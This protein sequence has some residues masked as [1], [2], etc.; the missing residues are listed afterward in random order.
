M[1]IL[2]EC[3][4][5]RHR[6]YDDTLPCKKCGTRLAKFSGKTYW[7]EFY[8]K[9]GR[10]KRERIG[11]NKALAETVHRKRLVERAEGKLLDKKKGDKIRFDQLAK[12]YLSLAEVKTKKSFIRDERSIKKLEYFFKTKLITSISPS[13]I[14]NYQSQRLAEKSYRGGETKAAT[15]NRE[16]ACLKTMFNKAIRDGKLEKNPMRGVKLLPENNERDRVL[17]IEEWEKY[18]SHCPAWYLPIATAAY[19]TAMRKGEILNLT[20][21]RVDLKEGFIRLRPEETKT[22]KGRSIPIHPELMEV[23]NNAM[24]VRHLN[25]E[26]VFHQDGKPITPHDVRVAHE[27]ACKEAGIEGFVFHDFR[28]TCINNWRKEGHDYFKI[29]AVSG[30]KTISV[31]KR[32]NMVDEAELKTLIFQIDTS[33]DTTIKVENKKEVSINA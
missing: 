23:L 24:K 26:L 25:C 33:V 18:K 28:H 4:K 2:V 17:S 10:R 7:I 20:I 1:A 14:G 19:R 8:T 30:H 31:F 5:C 9:E 3:P 16:I 29:M 11:P 22:S 12:H 27:L 21:P 15:V 13:L 6:Q 32:Y